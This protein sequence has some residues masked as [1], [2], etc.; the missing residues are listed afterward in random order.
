MSVD[1]LESFQRPELHGSSIAVAEGHI[2]VDEQ[3]VW[4]VGQLELAG[5]GV[6]LLA[7]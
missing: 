7:G 2:V 6:A 5:D 3:H 4:Q 1:K